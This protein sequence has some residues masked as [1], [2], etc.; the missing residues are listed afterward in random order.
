MG[1]SGRYDEVLKRENHMQAC[2]RECIL[3]WH[4]GLLMMGCVLQHDVIFPWL[5]NPKSLGDSILFPDAS[6]NNYTK[7]P[8][9]IEI[10]KIERTF[11]SLIRVRRWLIKIFVSDL[12]D[13]LVFS[14]FPSEK[15]PRF[16]SVSTARSGL[17]SGG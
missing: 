17:D 13:L 2:N 10:D 5:L 1:I 3:F 6:C 8:Q 7:H 11:R 4:L 16:H 12:L 9:Q 14:F 15:K